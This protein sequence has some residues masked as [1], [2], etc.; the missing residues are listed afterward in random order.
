MGDNRVLFADDFSAYALGPIPNDYSPWGEY[1]CRTDQGRLGPWQEATTHYSWRG[2]KGCWRVVTDGD[3]RAMEQQHWTDKSYPL[4]VTGEENWREY[5]ARVE[6]RLLSFAAP[7]GLVV[8]YRHSRDFLALLASQDGLRLVHR[9]HGDDTELAAV[10]TAFGADCYRAIELRCRVDSLV[11]VLDG[12]AVAEVN[13]DFPGGPVGLIANAPARFAEFRVVAT[14]TETSSLPTRREAAA[15]QIKQLRQRYPQPRLWKRLDTKGFGTDRNLRVG[16]LNGDGRNELVLAQSWSYLGEDNYCNIACLTA[17]DLDGNVLWQ[18]GS[19]TGERHETTSDLC[20]QLH[21]LDG[22]GRTELVYTSDLEL[23]VAD[24]ATGT[25]IRSVPTPDSAPPKKAAGAWPMARV[26]GDC[27]F[28]ADLRGAGRSDTLV[29][30]DRY[31]RGWVYDSDL[32]LLWDHRCTTGHYPASYDLDGDGRE[33]LMLGYTLLSG[34]GRVLW[35][36]DTFDHADGTVMGPIGPI[37]PIDPMTGE[38]TP[39]RLAL[40]GSDAGFFLLS[41]DGQILRHHNIGHAQTVSAL[42]LRADVPGLQ[43]VVNTYWG[44]PGV[45]LIM[46]WEGNVLREFEPMHYA[47][48]LHPVNWTHDDT[49]LV[50]LSTHPVE[51]GMIDGHGRRVVMFPDDG[52]PC[53][54][55]DSKDLDG[56]GIDE[57]LTWDYDS[58]WIYKP[59]PAP[60][61]TPARYPRRNPF[62]NDSNYSGQYSF[63]R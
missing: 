17:L 23:R 5:T 6:V 3:R 52:H 7:A 57:I 19:P 38:G 18:R 1:H 46:D 40:T 41:A 60:D 34:D 43:L 16:D 24:G 37:G 29:L 62:F 47:S 13:A 15:R 55:C 30:K 49:E 42:K 32:N 4:L 2:S 20:F 50:L 48:L 63:P 51:G 54:C 59:T 39:P 9:R 58:I 61:K 26:V 25:T 22:D 11:V 8:G 35:E 12:V 33:E 53:L 10:E 56:D 36:L 21:D 44:E 27:L 14:E 45:T 31:T 28:F